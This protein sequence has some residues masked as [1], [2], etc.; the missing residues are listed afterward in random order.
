MEPRILSGAASI[1]EWPVPPKRRL[2]FPRLILQT[3]R[4]PVGS[5]SED[6][7]REKLIVYRWLG[8]ESAFVMD[9]PLIQSVLLDDAESYSKQPL[10]DE[11]FGEAIGGGLLNAEGEAWRWQRRLTAPLFRAEDVLAYVPAFAEAC[12]P[13]LRRWREAPA[14]TSQAIDRDMTRATLQALQDSVLGASLGEEDRRSIAQ[15]GAAFLGYSVWKIAMTSL[16]LPPWIPHPGSRV[17]TCAGRTMRD[18]AARVLANARRSVEQRDVLLG[19]LVTARDPATGEAMPDALI[20]DNVVTFLM[21]GHETTSQAITWTL[22]LLALFPD[23]QEAV[24]QETLSV[25]RGRAIGREDIGKLPLLDAVFQE[26][27]RLYPPAPVLMR[28]A[29]RPVT[30]GGVTLGAGATISIPVYIVHRHRSLWHDPLRF[31]PTRFSAEARS[32]RHR[33]TY[34]PFGAGPRTCVGGSFAMLEGKTI[35]AMLLQHASFALPE[36]ERPTPFARI[37]LS[38]KCG[39]KLNVT[40]LG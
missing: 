12:G 28:R 23:W 33:C 35:L 40:M 3:I 24:R 16:R 29:I 26:A 30:L 5:W 10:N 36:G 38:P 15:A 1:T 37:T 6:F 22:Y 13:V 25:T 20:V 39:L 9:P 14:G 11:V 21:A 27:M 34:M 32:G 31:D 19:R 7:Y 4:N 8:L 18:I 2:A 17:M